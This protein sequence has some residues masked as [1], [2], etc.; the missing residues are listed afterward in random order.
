MHLR[1]N[2]TLDDLARMVNPVTR[3]WIHYYGR[4]RRSQLYPT[5][6]RIDE[7]LVRWL[8]HKYKRFKGS[9]GRAY[10]FLVTI[11]ER[12]PALFAHWQVAALTA[13]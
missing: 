4:Y 1:T 5:L 8:M 7:Y 9:S 3:G 12:Q 2:W 10:A 13:G 6:R 11:K